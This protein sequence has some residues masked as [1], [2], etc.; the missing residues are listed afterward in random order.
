[1]EVLLTANDIK[2]MDVADIDDILHNIPGYNLL[3][4]ETQGQYYLAFMNALEGMTIN[5]FHV[6]MINSAIDTWRGENPMANMHITDYVTPIQ[7]IELHDQLKSWKEKYDALLLR[8]KTVKEELQVAKAELPSKD[9]DFKWGKNETERDAQARA[10]L[11]ELHEKAAL[12]EEEIVELKGYKDQIELEIRKIGMLIA[13][14][15]TT[16]L[17]VPTA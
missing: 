15:S 8:Q 9:P 17:P 13:M 1:M 10:L 14:F 2:T 6:I 4:K 12:V 5:P 7:V 16:V 11:P 3:K